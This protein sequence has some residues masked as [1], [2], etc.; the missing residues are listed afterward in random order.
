MLIIKTLECSQISQILRFKMIW[1]SS[2]EKIIYGDKI[3]TEV[4]TFR[5]KTGV[6]VFFW[7]FFGI[8]FL[9]FSNFRFFEITEIFSD[10]FFCRN[11]FKIFDISVIFDIIFLFFYGNSRFFR[12]FLIIIFLF[13]NFR[14]VEILEIKNFF[15]NFLN[16]SFITLWR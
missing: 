2:F 9:D 13:R 16:S 10:Y 1:S 12:K 5:K 3:C 7:I 6:F 4:W 14:F 8:F 11:D 15:N